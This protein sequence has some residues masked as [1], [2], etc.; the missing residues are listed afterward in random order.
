MV[1]TI[2]VLLK[3]LSGVYPTLHLWLLLWEDS[4]RLVLASHSWEEPSM[5]VGPMESP[6]DL[7]SDKVGGNPR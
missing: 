4:S 5:A 1:I 6:E 7:S 2:L 3:V